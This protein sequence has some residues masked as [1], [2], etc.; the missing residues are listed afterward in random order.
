[1][2]K[3]P[4]AVNSCQHQSVVAKSTG[5]ELGIN[6]QIRHHYFYPLTT[7]QFLKRLW[8]KIYSI[9]F[10]TNV[11]KQRSNNCKCDEFRNGIRM[12]KLIFVTA[13]DY[14][15][16]CISPSHRADRMNNMSHCIS[17]SISSCFAWEVLHIIPR[18][19]ERQQYGLQFQL[20]FLSI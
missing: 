18:I 7:K 3:L 8:I 19:P 12:K 5:Q 16:L 2:R 1:M 20:I 4:D 14:T 9:W 10:F 15:F 11:W 17:M 6:L 13:T